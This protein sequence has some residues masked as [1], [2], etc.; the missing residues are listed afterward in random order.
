MKSDLEVD[1]NEVRRVAAAL[2]ATAV[3]IA[4]A[5]AAQ[6]TTETTPRWATTDAAASTDEAARHQLALIS[7]DL[8][9]AVRRITATLAD[10]EQTD[11]R[12]ATRLKLTQ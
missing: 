10:Y 9:D 4:T 3:R 8:T 5:A 12:A 11:A 2:A 6:P 7:A 1:A